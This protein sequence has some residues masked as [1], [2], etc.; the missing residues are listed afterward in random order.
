[1]KLLRFGPDGYEQPGIM[2]TSGQIRDLS[3]VISN[4]DNEVI[5]PKG[6]K[7]LR[8]VDINSLPVIKGNPRLGVPFIG[9]S[10][11]VCVGLNYSDHAAESGMQVPAE[12]VLFMKATTSITGP[13][14]KVIIP[15]NSVKTDW[16]V[17]LGV[18]IGT[19]A[20]YVSE[21]KALEYVAG[22]CIVNDVSEREFQLERSGQW[23]KGK[24]ADTFS[25]IGPRL[26]TTDEIT[27]PQ[28]LSMWLE[29]NGHR[30]QNGNTRTMVF[31][32]E[33]L[34]SYIS[35]FMTLLPG[36][37]ISTGTP[38]GVGLGLKPP[39]YLKPGDGMKLGIQGLGQQQ[40]QVVA[41][42]T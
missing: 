16:E 42:G 35:N 33:K 2:D 22:Y 18:V 1:M 39:K 29:V 13:N 37:V 7:K 38:P 31:G 26:V 19:K 41:W 20:Q 9:I 30:Y 17:E 36:D 32:V 12:P 15:K 28:A 14:D 24:S 4:I 8:E 40:Q 21:E 6:L 3:S 5:S 25:P 23:V 10:K 34:V 11:L 27:N